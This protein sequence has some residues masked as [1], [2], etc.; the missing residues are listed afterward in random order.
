MSP[1]PKDPKKLA[2]KLLAEYLKS[3][4]KGNSPE[5][6]EF[7]KSAAKQFARIHLRAGE[8]D[9]Q[10]A[11]IDFSHPVTT[12]NAQTINHANPKSRGFLGLGKKPSYLLT[13]NF[14]PKKPEDPY[15][16]LE[17]FPL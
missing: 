11:N 1:P 2:E 8:S 6:I 14:P 9:P 10:L 3:C 13:Q 16:A 15:Y 7:R 4:A 12:V 5:Q 17:Y